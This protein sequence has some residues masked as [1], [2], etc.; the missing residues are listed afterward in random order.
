MRHGCRCVH[1][2]S[3]GS[4]ACALGVL[5]FIRFHWVHAGAPSWSPGS[6]GVVGSTRTRPGGRRDHSRSF[7]SL[8]CVLV[9]FVLCWVPA[10][11]PCMSSGSIGYLGSR[12]CA[13]GFIGFILVRWV[14]S[15]ASWVW[16]C[17][18]MVVGFTRV[19]LGDCRLYLLSLGSLRCSLGV[20]WFIRGVRGA[21]WGRSVPFGVVG[22]TPVRPGVVVFIRGVWVHA[23]A[24][25]V[26]F[27]SFGVVGCWVHPGAPWVSSESF[28]VVGVRPAGQRV[29]SR[30]LGSLT[31][32]LRVVGN[33]RCRWVHCGEPLWLLGSFGFDEFIHM[34]SFGVV[35]FIVVRQG[36]VGFIQG[37]WAHSG[38]LWPSS[39][40]FRVPGFIGL[41]GFIGM[42]CV[43][44][45][46][47]RVLPQGS[48]GS[49]EFGCSL[50]VVGFNRE[51]WVHSGAPC[52]S[53]GSFGVV[54][55]TRLR[56]WSS[57][58]FGVV[59]FSRVRPGCRLVD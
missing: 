41:V 45:G 50:G 13:H 55:F 3:L 19:R 5:R 2:G 26:S 53:W 38:V 32:V 31:C 54:R 30:S 8:W 47:P 14:H 17:S 57:G 6:F 36:V 52:G 33:I 34:H 42:R 56:L 27:A 9:V 11:T 43:H 4:R 15:D 59:G 23:S 48:S 49:S 28:G 35:G 7:G 25:W 46:A 29:H 21:P 44:W 37:R 18:F 39:G 20:V 1:S 24:S 12:G 10:R 16:S 22:F 58:S 51:R 40:S